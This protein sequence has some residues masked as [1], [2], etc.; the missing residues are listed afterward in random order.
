MSDWFTDSL[1]GEVTGKFSGVR[2][3]E[4]GAMLG[5]IAI[6]FRIS[7]AVD[8]T[9]MVTAA[10]ENVE[11]PPEAGEMDFDHMDIEVKYTGEGTILWNL[12]A[13]R[14]H[15]LELSGDFSLNID[16]G[17]SMNMQGMGSMDLEQTIQMSG[18]LSQSAS[19]K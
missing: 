18:T 12:D 4:D 3:G 2:D 10:M 5:A 13:G 15:S 7:N 14:A 19:V 1:E 8:V 11:L 16:M 17:M 6:Q 9:E